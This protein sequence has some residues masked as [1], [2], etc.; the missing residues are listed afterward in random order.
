MT[1]N[2]RKMIEQMGDSLLLSKHS[3]QLSTLLLLSVDLVYSTFECV[4]FVVPWQN[5]CMVRISVHFR[6]RTKKLINIT[7]GK[8]WLWIKLKPC[9]FGSG[10]RKFASDLVVVNFFAFLKKK[11][12]LVAWSCTL[13]WFLTFCKKYLYSKKLKYRIWTCGLYYI[14]IFLQKVKA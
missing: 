4:V 9:P 11:L 13:A 10:L 8:F 14:N 3:I 12:Q 1:R 6:V 2:C 7:V 5:K